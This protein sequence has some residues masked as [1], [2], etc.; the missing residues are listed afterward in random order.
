MANANSIVALIA[1]QAPA[2]LRV[3]LDAVVTLE[4]LVAKVN[5]QFVAVAL[6]NDVRQT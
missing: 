2:F 5:G 3:V 4:A 1:L 6:L